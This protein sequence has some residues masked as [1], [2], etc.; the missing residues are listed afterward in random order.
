MKV[1]DQRPVMI[2]WKDTLVIR[3]DP[4]LAKEMELSEAR[5]EADCDEE[6]EAELAEA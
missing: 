3:R 1:S 4:A 2:R 5:D 6:W